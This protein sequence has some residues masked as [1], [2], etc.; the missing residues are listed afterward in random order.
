VRTF[1]CVDGLE[2]L[3]CQT[4]LSRMHN[5]F[6][7]AVLDEVWVYQPSFPLQRLGKHPTL[8][9]RIP[10]SGANLNGYVDRHCPHSATHLLLAFL[11]IEEVLLLT[12]DDGDVIGFRIDDIQ[13]A[14][15]RRQEPDSPEDV[16][17]TEI[18]PFMLENVGK[19]AWGLAVHSEAR[20]I[21]V[22]ANTHNVTVFEFALAANGD[23]SDTEPR[24]GEHGQ[25]SS[26]VPKSMPGSRTEDS[27][28]TLSGQSGNIPCV[29]F[30]NT[31]EDSAGRFIACGDIN[32]VTYVWDLHLKRMIEL[33]QLV[34]CTQTSS[35]A[36]CACASSYTTS[37]PHMGTSAVHFPNPSHTR[38]ES[39][40][41]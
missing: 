36:S 23:D 13:R 27:R 15:E 22:S 39:T 12:C 6:I 35:G 34:F 21:A 29:A 8:K 28:Y 20:K 3:T 5:I 30:C 4:G 10:K 38:L 24:F 2:V 17:A 14:I 31:G 37:F 1:A 33:S 9:I 11:G 41:C 16:F 32:G 26:S 40:R 25:T 7:V 18:R 19:S